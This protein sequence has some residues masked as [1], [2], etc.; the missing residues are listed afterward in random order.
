MRLITALLLGLLAAPAL[1]DREALVWGDS[2][3]LSNFEYEFDD[4]A[5][6]WQEIQ[7]RLPPYPKAENLVEFPVSAATRNRYYIDYDSISVGTDGV[8]R[9][10]VL[11]RSPAGAETLNFEGMRCETGE[12]KLYA[13][14]RQDGQGGGA[15]SRNRYAKWE[16]VPARLAVSHQRELFFHYLCTVDTAGD[17][18]KIRYAVKQGGV[19]RGE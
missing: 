16:P 17:L 4:N 6:T 10:S 3:D 9:Y 1:A 15:W 19:R 7:T 14:G 13:F 2:H 12:R 18:K 11:I 8:V 5:K